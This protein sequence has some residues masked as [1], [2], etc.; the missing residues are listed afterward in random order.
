[1]MDVGRWIL[2][3]GSAAQRQSGLTGYQHPTSKIQNPPS[4]G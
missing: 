1:M 2:D 3:V 4:K